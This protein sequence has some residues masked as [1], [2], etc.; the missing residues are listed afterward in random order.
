VFIFALLTWSFASNDGILDAYTNWATERRVAAAIVI[1]I[2]FFA[3]IL[4]HELSHSLVAKA[5]GIPVSGI[6]L[7]VFGG[8]SNLSR[9]AQSAGEEF[10]IAIVGPLTSIVIGG[11]FGIAWLALRPVSHAES[12]VAGYLAFINIVIGLFNLLPGYPLDGGRV[13]RAVMWWR[14]HDML[15][16]TR[17]AARTGVMVAYALMALGAVQFF[18]NPIGG[19]WM[20]MIGLFLR[21]ASSGSYEQLVVQQTIG[22]LTAGDLARRDVDRVDPELKVDRLVND[23][24]LMGKGRA[25]PVMAGDELLGLI[26]LTDVQHLDRASWETTSVYRAMTPREKLRTVSEHEPAISVLQMMADGDINQVPV[27]NSHLLIGMISRADIVRFINDRRA[28]LI[29]S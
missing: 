24:M 19:I 6:T 16:A 9:E 14:N 13:L 28:L 26:T 15:R 2:V 11:L 4:A 7:F 5:R 29:E 23:H 17:I 21:N 27:M 3:S 1:A 8:V 18:Y 25:Y 10:Q 20:F 12:N 22:S